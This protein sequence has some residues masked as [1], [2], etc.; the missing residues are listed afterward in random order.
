MCVCYGNGSWRVGSDY[1]KAVQMAG[2]GMRKEKE[3]MCVY[4][5]SM[6]LEKDMGTRAGDAVE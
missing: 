3:K 4:K 5:T 6:W 2:K 1:N